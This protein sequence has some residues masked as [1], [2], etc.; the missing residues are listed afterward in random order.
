M[1]DVVFELGAVRRCRWCRWCFYLCIQSDW[2]YLLLFVTCPHP[3]R[4]RQGRFFGVLR[5]VETT[6]VEHF[7][8]KN[9]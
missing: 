5:G 8:N 3:R 2:K 4:S 1:V 6:E 7:T 9:K